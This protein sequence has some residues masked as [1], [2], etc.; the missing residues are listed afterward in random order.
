MQM[1]APERKELPV[2]EAQVPKDAGVEGMHPIDFKAFWEQNQQNMIVVDLRGE[3]RASGVIAG[4]VHVPA[5]D[6]LKQIGT[7]VEKFRDQPIVAFFCQYSAHRAPT[8]A[9]FFRKSCPSKQRVMVLEGG[10]R[11]WEAHDLPIQQMETTVS[12]AECDQL[13]LKI[14]QNVSKLH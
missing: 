4:T 1:K 8:V 2:I 5:M 13:A 3:D 14:G 12:Q 6:L 9:N 7:Y 11:G 10:F